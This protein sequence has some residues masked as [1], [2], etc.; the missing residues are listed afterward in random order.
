MWPELVSIPRSSQTFAHVVNVSQNVSATF[1]NHTIL[2]FWLQNKQTVRMFS[3]RDLRSLD[4]LRAQRSMGFLSSLPTNQRGQKIRLERAWSVHIK[5]QR[6]EHTI[7]AWRHFKVSLSRTLIDG[8]AAQLA[9]GWIWS[10]CWVIWPFLYSIVISYRQ[11]TGVALNWRVT[12]LIF[13]C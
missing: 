2:L 13:Y 3:L 7:R 9:Y 5:A 10:E 1:D 11:G 4:L 12:L 6:A 8:W